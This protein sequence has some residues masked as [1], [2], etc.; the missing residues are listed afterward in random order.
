MKHL[1][2]ALL[3]ALAACTSTTPLEREYSA[4][5]TDTGAPGYELDI[6]EFCTIVKGLNDAQCVEMIGE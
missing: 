6:Y 2:L 4:Y 5:V 1:T 3:T